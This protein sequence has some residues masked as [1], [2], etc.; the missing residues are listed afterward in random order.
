M[1]PFHSQGNRLNN[2]P[3]APNPS[4][5]NQS[6]GSSGRCI[7]RLYCKAGAWAAARLAR[8]VRNL[9]TVRKGRVLGAAEAAAHPQ[10]LFFRKAAA[11]LL[12]LSTNWTRPTQTV[13]DSLP[14]FRSPA[15]EL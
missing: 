10:H 5:S 1:L 3:R 9:G 12:G 2:S 13:E 7:I 15:L 8:Q 6:S 14:Y 4:G 11:L